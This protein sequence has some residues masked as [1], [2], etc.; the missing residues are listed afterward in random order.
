VW[1]F[2]EPV[3]EG[4]PRLAVAIGVREAVNLPTA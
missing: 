3:K 4:M 2:D 1:I